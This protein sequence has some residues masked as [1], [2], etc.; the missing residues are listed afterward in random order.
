MARLIVVRFLVNRPIRSGMV[1]AI[2]DTLSAQGGAYEPHLVRRA[3]GEGP[4]RITWSRPAGLLDEVTREGSST[5]FLHVAEGR[6]EPVLSFHISR[7]VRAT[8][9]QVSLTIPEDVLSSTQEVERVLGVSKGL[10]L[11]LESAWGTIHAAG[12]EAEDRPEPD[13]RWAN[14]FGP[15]IATRVGPARLLTSSAFIVEI[16]PDG[17]IML[18]THPVPAHADV[19]GGRA[20]RMQ[21]DLSTGVGDALRAAGLGSRAAGDRMAYTSGPRVRR[22]ASPSEP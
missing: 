14:F 2:L 12:E 17:G 21:L 7:S 1:R 20:L 8:P 19:A 6:P 22:R 10:Y 5:T 11:F 15:E 9:S 13:I 4:Q 3:S 16:L 18:V